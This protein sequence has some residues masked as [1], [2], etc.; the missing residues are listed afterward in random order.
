MQIRFILCDCGRHAHFVNSLGDWHEPFTSKEEGRKFLDDA[1][2]RN[3]LTQPQV[4]QLF[5]QVQASGLPDRRFE[6]D[7][8]LRD[9]LKEWVVMLVTSNGEFQPEQFHEFF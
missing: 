1:L 9:Q 4:M 5:Q 6:S 7:P 2:K 8:E 3:K